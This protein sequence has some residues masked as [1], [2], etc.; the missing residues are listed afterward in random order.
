MPSAQQSVGLAG[1]NAGLFWPQVGIRW[2][3]LLLVNPGFWSQ[4]SLME[5]PMTQSLGEQSVSVGRHAAVA[6]QISNGGFTRFG[7]FR[8][9]IC[10]IPF[11]VVIVCGPDFG[12]LCP[13]VGKGSLALGITGRFSAIVVVVTVLFG[14]LRSARSPRDVGPRVAG[15]TVGSVGHH[16]PIL[17]E[18]TCT[19]SVIGLIVLQVWT[20]LWKWGDFTYRRLLLWLVYGRGSLF[21]LIPPGYILSPGLD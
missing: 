10:I 9:W 8:F 14:A 13:S 7:G 18:S 17:F 4:A 15:V 19:N 2:Y 1:G 3:Q 16:Q 5:R 12:A 6:R 11:H 20:P 21:D